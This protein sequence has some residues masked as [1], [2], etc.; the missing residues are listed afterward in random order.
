MIKASTQHG[1][2]NTSLIM[3]ISRHAH[4]EWKEN[5]ASKSLRNEP[6]TRNESVEMN[7]LFFL[8]TVSSSVNSD[9]CPRGI[10]KLELPSVNEE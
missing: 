4:L 5:E 10:S 6:W 3:I 2:T 7:Y 9:K 8:P 1:N